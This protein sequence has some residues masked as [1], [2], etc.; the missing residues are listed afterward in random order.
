MGK[1]PLAFFL[2]LLAFSAAA[3]TNK[4]PTSSGL[5]CT[6]S[7]CPGAFWLGGG[8]GGVGS[9]VDILGSGL[10]NS[11]FADGG[12]PFVEATYAAWQN[13]IMY[14]ASVGGG[15]QFA[16]PA[17]IGAAS[18]NQSQPMGWAFFEAGGNLFSLFGSQTAPTVQTAL[19]QDLVAPY[20][21]TGPVFEK[22]AT[23]WG[24]GAGLRYLVSPNVMFDIKYVF[25]NDQ[26]D[27]T[28][29]V[30][31]VLASLKWKF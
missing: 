6:V 30:Q 31:L 27:N 16:Q 11:V 5:T 25:A 17:S 21:F 20:A 19:I 8:V 4:A 3:Q 18:N 23:L 9:N 28:K 7:S 13:N 2:S 22:G 29:N 14:G 1:F 12:I 10:D 24:N 26:I 15:Y